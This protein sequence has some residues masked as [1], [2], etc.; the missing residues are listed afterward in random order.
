MKIGC[1]EVPK[2]TD[3]S[4]PWR[5]E[6]KVPVPLMIFHLKACLQET[7]LWLI[8]N[9]RFSF[10]NN[11]FYVFDTSYIC[12]HFPNLSKSINLEVKLFHPLLETSFLLLCTLCTSKLSTFLHEFCH[13]TLFVLA[14]YSRQALSIQW[15]LEVL[16][17]GGYQKELWK[18]CQNQ[19]WMVL[20]S[21][22]E[23]VIQNHP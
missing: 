10:F 13:V 6:W 4:L 9:L 20:V 18:V 21:P 22:N 15:P 19:N 7:Y 14:K 5:A 1:W 23:G 17:M 3:P 16:P 11:L 2:P 12:N 8:I